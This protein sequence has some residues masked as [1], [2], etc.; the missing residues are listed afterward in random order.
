MR[1]KLMIGIAVITVVG[2]GGVAAAAGGG[3][4][5]SQAGG[6]MT[7]VQAGHLKAAAAVAGV[8]TCTGGAVKKVKQV[9]DANPQSLSEGTTFTE[10]NTKITFN[11]PSSGTDT[12]FVTFSAEAQLR[13]STAGDNFDWIELYLYVDGYPVAP[14]GGP[15]DASPLGFH[16]GPAYSADSA[17]YCFTRSAG[18]FHLTVKAVLRDNGTNDV[19]TAWLDDAALTL[20]QTD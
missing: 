16:G 9:N 18:T 5:S 10:P 13:G 6:P 2:A 8:K 15:T 4:R 7:S 11:G 3:T 17:Q 20:V 12:F 1:T 19:L 14:G